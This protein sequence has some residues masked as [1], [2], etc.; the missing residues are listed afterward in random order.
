MFINH[1]DLTVHDETGASINVALRLPI[2]SQLELKRKYNETT[3]ETLLNAAQDDEKLIEVITKSLNWK[4][5]E[6]T[7]KSGETLL[8]LL[9]DDGDIGII[10]RQRLMVELGAVS[11]IFSVKEKAVIMKRINNAEAEMLGELEN[12]EDEDG[13]DLSKN[14]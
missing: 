1:F 5:N 10:S 3:R 8:E 13:E 4:G 14:S 7:V 9:I 11:G 6:N 2:G 12:I